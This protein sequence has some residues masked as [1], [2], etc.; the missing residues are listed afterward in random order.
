[1]FCQKYIY[2]GVIRIISKLDALSTE[3][4]QI[5]C[6]IQ[7]FYYVTRKATLFDLDLKHVIR[8]SHELKLRTVITHYYD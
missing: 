3:P 8:L 5:M 2:G 6:K 4:T 1:M 7:R